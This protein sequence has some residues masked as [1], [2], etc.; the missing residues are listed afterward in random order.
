MIIAF[1]RI[2]TIISTRPEI[3]R[4]SLIIK[5]LDKI[6]LDKHILIHTGQNFTKELDNDIFNDLELRSPNIKLNKI[7]KTGYDFGGYCMKEIENI[8]KNYNPMEDKI[9]ILGDVNGAFYSAYVAKKM[10]FKIFHM[11]SGNRCYDETVP[12][13][14]NRRAIDSFSYKLLTYTQRSRENLLQ[15]GYKTKDIIVVG[16]PIYEVIK[17][18]KIKLQSKKQHILVTFHRNENVTNKEKLFKFINQLEKI[19]E[20]EKKLKIFISVHPKLKDMI[21]KNNIVINNKNIILNKPFTFK[22]FIELEANAKC[23]ITDSGTIPEECAIFNTP[24]ILVRDS[25]E[26][27]ELLEINQMFISKCNN[28]Y[29]IYNQISHYNYNKIPVDYK[30]ETSE[31][32]SKLL[33]GDL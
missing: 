12:E 5:K 1:M 18:E 15:E 27:P 29:N 7:K 16:N 19:S 20:N 2:I 11:E 14:I 3:I 17:N 13:E 8:L 33:I 22:E 31:I 10:G 32:V 23:V 28:V 25:T 24:C 21:K 6:L 9:L 30:K 4:L 26:R